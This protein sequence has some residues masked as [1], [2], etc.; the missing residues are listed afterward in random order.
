MRRSKVKAITWDTVLDEL[1]PE[2]TR[3]IPRRNPKQ[4]PYIYLEDTKQRKYNSLN[5]LQWEVIED[6]TQAAEICRFLKDSPFPKGKSIELLVRQTNSGEQ[7]NSDEVIYNWDQV[8]DIVEEHLVKTMKASSAKNIRADIRNLR[9]AETPFIWKKVRAWIFQKDISSRPFKNRLDALE[10]LRLAISSKYGDEPEWLQRKD[11]VTLREQNNASRTKAKRYQP[12]QDLGGVRAIPTQK[13]AEQYFDGLSDEYEL[14]RW[15][16]A[17]MMCYGMRNHELWHCSLVE[18]DPSSPN[19]KKG[20]IMIPG[21]WRTKSK[22]K[23]WT[24]PIFPT[25]INK[26]KLLIDFEIMQTLLHKRAKPRIMSAVDMSQRWDKSSKKDLGVCVNND[27]LGNWISKQL[28]QNLP[29]WLASV[30][31]AKGKFVK[32]GEKETVKPYDL[33]HTWAV[34]LATDPKWSH[35]D[36]NDAALCM[37]HNIDIHR[38]HYQ[39]WISEDVTRDNLFKR[40]TS[41]PWYKEAV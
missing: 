35:I 22:F 6:V 39:R 29:E 32:S 41:I 15:C 8:M 37:G 12:G 14:H 38:K 40:I 31:N 28:N 30:P 20:L 24:F 7:F 5:P 23:H 1:I 33:R 10:Q 34:T 18:S 17:M 26:Y 4:S 27:Y 21:N 2:G 9:N 25:W 3:H 36:E 13:E 11:L 16:L 19:Y